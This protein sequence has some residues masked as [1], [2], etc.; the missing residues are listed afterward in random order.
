M[1][2]LVNP[3]PQLK[4]PDKFFN[5]PEVRSYFERQ[6]TILFQLWQRSG[7]SR[8]AVAGKQ[9]V[10]IAGND[11]TLDSSAYGAL[12]I[13]EA[14]TAPVEIILPSITSDT[15][16]ETVDVAILDA[17]FDV[18]VTSG[19]GDTVFGE[20]CVIMNQK[21]MSIQFTTISQNVWIG[22]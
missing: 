9:V 15:V 20:P 3:P 12:I 16:G 4:I 7:G 1:S 19:S 11:L 13:V 5:D 10:I 8:D 6:N 2:V 22:T 17:T 14:D 21:F 18:T